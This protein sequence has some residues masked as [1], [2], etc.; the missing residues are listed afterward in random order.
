MLV[1]WNW[2]KKY[3]SLDMT[4]AEL[5]DRL[6][7][8]GLNHEGTRPVGDDLAIDLE[9]ASNRPDCL[10]HIGVARE[11]AVLWQ[12]P[13]TLPDPQPGSSAP[14]V[15]EHASVKIECP[16][17]CPRYTARVVRGVSIGPSPDWLVDHL[18]TVLRPIN[19]DW[20]PVNNVVDITNF[21][22]L[23]CGQP[24]H[25][26]DLEKIKGGQVIIRQAQPDEPFTAIDHSE[27]KLQPG[28]CVIADQSRA[29]ALGG[30]MGGAESEVSS[31]TTSLLIE[32]ARFDPLSIRTTARATN[33]HSPSSH[34]FERGVDPVGIEWASRRCC[35]MILE[36][37]GGELAEGIIDVGEAVS[38]PPAIVL[39]LSQLK[40]ILGIE[41][42]R[43]EV[44][45]I[46]NAL[47]NRT[48]DGGD[49]QLEVIAPSW[50]RD[51]S[52]EIDLVEEVARIHGY[53]KIPEDVGVPMAP[54]HRSDRD[55]VEGAVRQTLVAA[56]LDEAMT[57]SMVPANWPGCFQAWTE[58]PP[59]TSQMPMLKGAD[60]LR[61]SLVPSLLEARRIN[62]SLANP[63]IELFETASVYLPS[64]E[65]IPTQQWT[66]AIVSGGGYY[67][68]KGVVEGLLEALKISVPL[69]LNAI[70]LPLLDLSRSGELRLG[71]VRLGILGDI[72]GEGLT[73]FSLRSTASILELNLEL[74]AELAEL[75]PQHRE[76][77]SFPTIS[78]D[79]N[80]ILAESVRWSQLE[81]VARE[82]AGDQLES[83]HYQETYRD[84]ERDGSDSKRILL[85]MT[86]RSSDGTMT[87]E[88]ADAL[89]EK[90]V[91]QIEKQLG[92]RLLS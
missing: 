89:R 44:E 13:I 52:R 53:D 30:V 20:Q 15:D 38:E 23:E 90:I 63:I 46:L 35:E 26:F 92:G 73:Q 32:S 69:Q 39:R 24:L 4:L 18:A 50:R 71:D 31:S 36:I 61:T 42:E 72:S 88:Q 33:L 68:L 45:R 41:V 21:V 80:I 70:D 91:A 66:L 74:L 12:Q 64:D 77:S 34:R 78:R 67:R 83:I 27:Y 22:L 76:L 57:A 9:V 65:Q 6:S 85:S 84:S 79:L 16:E 5:E 48:T 58:S 17:L 59:I 56:G 49:G 25:A 11:I 1:S 3:V 10:G 8:S 29:I 60:T 51:L 19:P 40:R 81:L 28:M 75:V 43:E 2:L 14:G 37:A 62:E 87:G 54:S 7:M 55:R 82:A 86:L 47:G